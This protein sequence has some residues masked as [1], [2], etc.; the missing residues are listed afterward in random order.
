MIFPAVSIHCVV[1][2]PF[3]CHGPRRSMQKPPTV[4]PSCY[5][6][7][8]CY[9]YRP[10]TGRDCHPPRISCFRGGERYVPT[11]YYWSKRTRGCGVSFRKKSR[12]MCGFFLCP[13]SCL[14]TVKVLYFYATSLWALLS[15][16]MLCVNTMNQPQ[17]GRRRRRKKKKKKRETH[18]FW[19]KTWP[20]ACVQRAFGL[21]RLS[22]ARDN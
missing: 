4:S 8:P 21:P 18:R 22:N 10:G 2:P 3:P 13:R 15:P 19:G 16:S 12:T 11:S 5:M 9:I 17:N 6:H 7:R 20:G 1:C 14:L